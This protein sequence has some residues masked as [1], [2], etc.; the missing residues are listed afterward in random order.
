MPRQTLKD[1]NSN[2]D[3]DIRIV[4]IVPG[5][6]SLDRFNS[7]GRRREYACR[8]LNMSSSA[9]ALA[10][11]VMGNPG[12]RVLAHID[13]L[14]KLKGTVGRPLAGG[15]IL[16]LT[17]TDDERANLSAKIAW[18]EIAQEPRR[19]RPARPGSNSSQKPPLI[20]AAVRW[21]DT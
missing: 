10:V 16:D 19:L 21:N 1:K 7:R 15:F 8:T 14:G 6:Y 4:A 12:E 13:D 17:A 11:P 2:L 5:R 18:F 20:P 3:D 9:I